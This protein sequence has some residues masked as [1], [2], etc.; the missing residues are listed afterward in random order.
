VLRIG[1]IDPVE[2]AQRLC[3]GARFTT[4]LAM[5][6]RVLARPTVTYQQRL[7][8]MNGNL[9]ALFVVFFQRSLRY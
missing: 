3:L 5:R 9:G 7:L 6:A 2:N 4:W 8:Q 1:N